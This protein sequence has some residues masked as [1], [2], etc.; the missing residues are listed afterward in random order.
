MSQAKGDPD[1]HAAVNLV[2]HFCKLE[3]GAGNL[4]FLNTLGTDSPDTGVEPEN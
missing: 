2:K 1:R 3:F 4:T